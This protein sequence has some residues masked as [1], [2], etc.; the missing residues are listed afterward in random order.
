MINGTFVMLRFKQRDGFINFI[1]KVSLI[2]VRAPPNIE[3]KSL[4]V[5]GWV[6][7]GV[8]GGL[9]PHLAS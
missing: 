9:W 5:G 4:A 3:R 8:G 7:G 6:R 2:G 1:L